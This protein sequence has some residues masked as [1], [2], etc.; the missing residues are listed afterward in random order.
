MAID[1]RKRQK[2]LEKRA[3][4]RKE[5][6]YQ[7]ARAGEQSLAQRLAAADKYPILH[8][9]TTTDLW[10]K[11]MGWVCMS[12]AL[13]GN[14]VAFAIFLVDRY[15]LGVKN[16]MC[17]VLPR[18]Q[19]DS[20]IERKTRVRFQVET[21]TPAAVRKLVEGAVAYADRLGLPPH[22]DYATASRIFG[23]VN[24]D[25]CAQEFEFGQNGKPYFI[26]GPND[27]TEKCRR[28]VAALKRTCGEGG[29]DYLVC[30]G[31]MELDEMGGRLMSEGEMSPRVIDATGKPVDV[32]PER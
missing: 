30:I 31:G 1:P 24:A 11:G 2:K 22:A 6:H 13:P 23:S 12:R 5:K 25:E 9:W 32:L 10:E 21:L 20:D 18:S 16:A 29:Y 19:Y 15:C 7:I 27:S 8:C 4:N 14:Q 17:N 26:S 28:I 3:T